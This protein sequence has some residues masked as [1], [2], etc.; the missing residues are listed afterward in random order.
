MQPGSHATELRIPLALP[1]RET[2]KLA[3]FRGE[4][5]ALVPG[6]MVEFQ[7][8]DLDQARGA[9]QQRGGVKVSVDGM[10]KNRALWEV[11]MRIEVISETVGLESHRGWVFQNITYLLDKT[12]EVIDHAGFETTRQTEREVGLA[13]FFELPEDDLGAYTWV[14]RTPAAIVRVPMEYELKDIPLP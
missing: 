5:T 10:R 9:Q 11:H 13:Y 14:Y 8:K 7:F 3:S 2:S 6:R 1:P 12:G 4:M